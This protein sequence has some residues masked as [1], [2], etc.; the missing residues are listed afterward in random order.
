[1]KNDTSV[2]NR[3]REILNGY[4]HSRMGLGEAMRE[5]KKILYTTNEN[6]WNRGNVSGRYF[7]QK[8]EPPHYSGS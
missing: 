7:N 3:V 4:K 2:S 1:M 8:G 6:W 5:M